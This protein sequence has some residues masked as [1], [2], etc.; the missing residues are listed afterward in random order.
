MTERPRILF[1]A[2]AGA[3]VGG[4]HVMRCLTLAQA[5]VEAGADCAFAA[6]P[7]AAAILDAFAEPTVE[8]LPLSDETVA[9]LAVQVGD[10]ARDWGAHAVVA[11]HYG[12]DVA[13]EMVIR[14]SVGLLTLLDDL[15]RPHLCDL[16]LDSN[17]D[18]SP[19]DYPGV[20]ALLGP[21]FALLRPQFA[22][23]R[24]AVLERRSTASAPR[25]ALVSLGL[26]DVGG[27]TGRVV[28]A[29]AP[30]LGEM[31]ADVVVGQGA[32]S[33][34]RLIA[35]AARDRRVVLHVDT[36]EMAELTAAADIAIGA[37]GS[38]SW[39]R[40]CL[41]LPALT[42]VL[43][44]NQVGAAR[45]LEA[46]GAVRLAALGGEAFEARLATALGQL[47]SDRAA[48]AAMSS[49]A[50]AI[51]DGRG[52]ERVAARLLEGLHR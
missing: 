50:A 7:A 23:L 32:P 12:L 20:G 19:D 51:C 5:L 49:A 40:C 38:S 24:P 11:D 43:A 6:T 30:M 22:A 10:R 21:Q 16:V 3:A 27:I 8:R 2:D 1:F 14:G 13:E 31:S 26:T 18:R 48:L 47:M 52:A 35:L 25:K 15:M 46:R 41:G 17:L 44:D 29:I 36:R 42:L 33:L 39:E 37:G 45:A 34:P 4:G 28:E 9:R